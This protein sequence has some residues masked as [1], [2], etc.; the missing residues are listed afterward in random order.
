MARI[1]W[2]PG[3]PRPPLAV[4][5]CPRGGKELYDEL[6]EIQRGGI[7]TLVSLLD[8]EQVDMLEL[9]DEGRLASVMGIR[10]IHHPLPDHSLPPDEAGFREFVSGLANRL[11]EGERVGVHCYGSIGRATM[12]AACALVHLGWDPHFALVAIEKTRGCQ[13]PDT[14]EQE[15]WILNYKPTA[16]A[17]PAPIRRPA[18]TLVPIGAPMPE[19]T[20]DLTF[21]HSWRAT[22]L[23][24][25]PSTIP[26]RH[27]I[28]PTEVE[29]VEQGALEVQVRPVAK[30]VQP[31]L[32]TCALGFADPALPNGIWSAPRK[33]EICAVSGGY[34]YLIDTSAPENFTMI[35]M[36]P[37]LEIRPILV[38]NLLLFIDNH[39]ILA[40]G[41]DGLA[42]E[43]E[44]LSDEGIKITDIAGGILHGTGWEMKSDKE[45]PFALD[46]PSGVRIPARE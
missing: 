3:N 36:R 44:K 1:F 39:M 19:P 45:T 46:L 13:V 31:F 10:F 5:L 2:I 21:A 9:A 32:A 20:L 34:A 38:Q 23:A 35:P 30:D 22:I 17:A 12:A 24:D 40:W 7:Q 16:V 14:A 27:Y 29:E 33:D 28:Y 18:P 8:D 25:N 43:S 26:A 4:L 15:E 37:V 42:W 11:R 41:A 6:R